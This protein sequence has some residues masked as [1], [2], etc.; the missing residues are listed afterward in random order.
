MIT[1]GGPTQRTVNTYHFFPTTTLP[2]GAITGPFIDATR[3]TKFPTMNYIQSIN[4]PKF[5]ELYIV[6]GFKLLSNT[7]NHNV[8]RMPNDEWR[9]YFLQSDPAPF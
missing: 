3:A 5:A 9:Y 2:A 7:A 8:P 1:I 4:I 6:E